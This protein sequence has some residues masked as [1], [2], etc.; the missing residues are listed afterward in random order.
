MVHATQR[1]SAR[2]CNYKRFR[3]G[4][5]AALVDFLRENC[6]LEPNARI[7]DV[8]SGTG[9]L[10]RVFLDAGF[11]VIGI[12]PNREMR[13]AGEAGALD[14]TAEATTLPESSIDL[15]VAGQA[16]HWFDPARTRV[17]WLR[18]LRPP[19]PVALIWNE[20]FDGT[21]FMR[22]MGAMIDRYA[23]ERDRDG[24]IREAGKGRIAGFF[25][26]QPYS[27]EEFPNRQT[28]HY[29][30]L[31]G[32]IVSS[33]YLPNEGDPDYPALASEVREIFERWQQEGS[34]EFEYRTRV[35]WGRL[36]PR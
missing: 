11:D 13:E 23:A 8:G 36:K 27:V 10:S 30:A 20:R 28:F 16:F 3:P 32:R 4:Y 25:A 18:I 14:A 31:L 22:E 6:P 33:S 19:G 9:L 35:Y 2:A 26:P 1:F 34:V 12:E 21:P 5:P 24:A 17:E 15:I 29:E 7:A